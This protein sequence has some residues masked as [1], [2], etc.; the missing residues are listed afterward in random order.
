MSVTIVIFHVS[1]YVLT[2]WVVSSVVVTVDIQ[3][4]VQDVMVSD[5]AII[6]IITDCLNDRYQRVC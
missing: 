4:M 1:T 3:W 6:H 5:N 2:H